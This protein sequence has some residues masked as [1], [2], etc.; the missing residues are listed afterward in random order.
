MGDPTTAVLIERFRKHLKVLDERIEMLKKLGAT[1][2]KT[3]PLP[4][5]KPAGLLNIP[6]EIRL[7]IYHYCIP[8]K[9]IVEVTHPRFPVR[10]PFEEEGDTLDFE[11]GTL[12]LVGNF[13][14]I[15]RNKNSLFL[16]S[17]QISEEALDFLYGENIFKLYLNGEGEYCLRKNFSEVNRR[18]M[19]YM[20][21]IAQ[22]MGV[23]FRP[24][25]IPDNALWSSILPNLK[26]FRLVAQQPLETASY[27]NAPTLEQ[28]VDD[29]V[30]WIRPF[31][32]CF[33]QHLSSGTVVE[34][35]D[36]D[37]KDTSELVK[38][39]LP[40]GYRKVR[41][42]LAGDLIFKRGQFSIESGYWDDDGPTNCRDIVGDCD[43][44]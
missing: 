16:V 5:N 39:R 17:K 10:W 6:F 27:Y 12:D 37:R 19:R 18:R 30:K 4:R 28:E 25:R 33:G 23:S 1:Q 8:R 26:A 44:D 14:N 38:E 24:G 7:Q 20:L 29:W 41:C 43:S 3:L 32:E 42:R 2:V 35:D 36:D 21:V 34:V 13:W 9:R 22:P 40:N 11:S 31:L 15:N